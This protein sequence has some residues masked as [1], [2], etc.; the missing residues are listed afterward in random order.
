MS[1]VPDVPPSQR[2]VAVTAL[3][4]LVTRAYPWT[5]PPSRKLKLWSAPECA[6]ANRPMAFLYEGGNETHTWQSGAVPKRTIE[7]RIFVY[8][9]GADDTVPGS[10]QLNQIADALDNALSGP[11]AID[12]MAGRNT[13]GGA[14]YWCRIEGNSLK[15]PGDIDA[16]DGTGILMIPVKITL[17]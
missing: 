12:P 16:S 3:L 6:K 5:V 15:V 10:P 7:V 17:P 8:T 14:A 4:D 13:L 9:D 11:C 1:V 2:E